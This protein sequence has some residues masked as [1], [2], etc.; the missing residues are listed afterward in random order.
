MG[1][2]VLLAQAEV[3]NS[4]RTGGVLCIVILSTE[5]GWALRTASEEIFICSSRHRSEPRVNPG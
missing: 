1:V 5:V 4:K 2:P 3:G